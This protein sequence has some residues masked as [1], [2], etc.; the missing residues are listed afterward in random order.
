MRLQKI[1][2]VLFCLL[3]T[4]SIVTPAARPQNSQDQTP[5]SDVGKI[6]L[7][8]SVTDHD[9]H[10]IT[11]L[12]AEDFALFEDGQ[13]Q[14]IASISSDVPACIGLVVDRSGSMRHKD[15]PVNAALL[16]FVRAGSSED[17]YFVVNFNNEPYLD[18]Q[19]TGDIRRIEEALRRGDARGATALYD[20]VV[21]SAEHLAKVRDCA[22]RLL[23]VVSDGGDNASRETLSQTIAAV[24][25]CRGLVLFT[26][27][28]MRDNPAQARRDQRALEALATGTGGE[29]F[30]LGN[31]KDVAK[32][33]GRVAEEIRSQYTV[34]YVPA[35]P[36][37]D[38]S[39]PKLKVDA[40]SPDHQN[41]VVRTSSGVKA[42]Q[43]ASQAPP[44]KT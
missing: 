9:H 16:D 29:S 10:P 25:N 4:E 2:K 30:F 15:A 22:K 23:V 32:A 41:L 40:R 34:S 14:Q 26:I 8:V 21:A 38:S 1:G 20:A 5:V 7:T 39:S 44:P 12:K 28:L 17:R 37:L 27:G 13:P 36:W 33:S 42:D 31:L 43:A 11:G 3:L 24:Q 18:V 6:T 35:H 19:L